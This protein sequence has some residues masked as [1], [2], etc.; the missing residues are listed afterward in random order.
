MPIAGLFSGRVL[1]LY[2]HFT[3]DLTPVERRLSRQAV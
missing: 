3:V 1:S 2:G